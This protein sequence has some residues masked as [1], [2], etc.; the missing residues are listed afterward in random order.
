MSLDIT[1]TPDGLYEAKATPPHI[2]SAW[3]TDA[4]APARRLYEELTV[5]AVIGYP[6]VT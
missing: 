3:S 1:I 4:P 5:N 2:K 6:S